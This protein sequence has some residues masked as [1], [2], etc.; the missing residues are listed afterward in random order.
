VV[1][2]NGLIESSHD[3]QSWQRHDVGVVDEF[4]RVVWSGKR[5][6][7]SGGKQAWTSPDGLG[8]ESGVATDP[9]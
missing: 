9:L 4:S 5:F 7:L 6:I 3:G 8:V 1:G 2:P